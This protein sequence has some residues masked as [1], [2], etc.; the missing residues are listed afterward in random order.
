MTR[1]VLALIRGYQISLAHIFGGQCRYY[2]S[3]SH[4]TY[5]AV[6][7]YGWARGSWMGMLRILRCHPFAKGGYDP[8]P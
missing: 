4:Y 7:R 5:E 3:C 2:P 6:E 1:A 8:V